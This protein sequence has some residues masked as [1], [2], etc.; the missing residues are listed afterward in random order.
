MEAFFSI[1]LSINSVFFGRKFCPEGTCIL[2]AGFNCKFA[3]QNKYDHNHDQSWPR[4]SRDSLETVSRL[5]AALSLR[6]Y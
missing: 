6:I 3:I 1:D 4:Q 2:N 5:S